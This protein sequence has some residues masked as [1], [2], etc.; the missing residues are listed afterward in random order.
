MTSTTP[1]APTALASTTEVPLW[2]PAL[3]LFI[4]L[5]LVAGLAYPLVITGI[6]QSVFP[7]QANGSLIVQD[8]KTVGSALIGQA[9]ADPGHFWSR[10]S[11]T[12]PMLIPA[13]PPPYPLT[14]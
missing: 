1:S 5:S 8:G 12:G 10:P 2:R 11:A 3:T 7:E 4:V 13:T 6:A 9:F 14:W